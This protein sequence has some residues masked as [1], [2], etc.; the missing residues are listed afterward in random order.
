MNDRERT[1][2]AK[3]QPLDRFGALDIYAE[4]AVAEAEATRLDALATISAGYKNDK[5]LPVRS[6]DGTIYLHDPEGRAPGLRAALEANEGKRL[7]ITFPF[8]DPRLFIQQRFAQYSKSRLLAYGDQFALTTISEKGVRNEL[9]AGTPAYAAALR[10]CKVNVSVFFNLVEWVE[11][12]GNVSPVITMPDGMGFYRLRFTG[13]NSLRS[14][15]GQLKLITQFTAGRIAGVPFDL[16][17]TDREVADPT[18][19]RR[20]IPVFTI[21]MRAPHL[22]LTS[23]NF[24]QLAEA[25]LAQADRLRLPEPLPETI[26]T[27]MADGEPYDLDAPAPALEAGPTTD[28]IAADSRLEPDPMPEPSEHDVARMR[29]ALDYDTERAR[30]FALVRGTDL[31]GD[32]AR[33]ELIESQFGD[34]TS[35][36]DVL[37]HATPQE[38]DDFLAYVAGTAQALARHRQDGLAESYP[39]DVNQTS[40]DWLQKQVQRFIDAG[41]PYGFRLQLISWLAGG[42]PIEGNSDITRDILGMVKDALGETKGRS[43]RPVPREAIAQY[44]DTFLGIMAEDQAAEA[45]APESEA[46]KAG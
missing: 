40:V 12:D 7:M 41:V 6:R 31:E 11:Q 14:F 39:D 27:A 32:E 9:R 29:S 23:Q 22:R 36:R 45:P 4:G 3:V 8:D 28:T 43:W 21:T 16:R 10:E 19:A 13:R 34:L 17:L 2:I 25:G 38:W 24:R 44:A 30:F 37:V 42:S 46:V 33:A 1:A 26:E 5:G 35:L 20:S 18:G 15:L